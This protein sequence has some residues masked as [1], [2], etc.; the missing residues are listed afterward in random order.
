[1]QKLRPREVYVLI[2]PN[3]VHMTLVA[4]SPTVRFL[5]I[6]CIVKMHSKTHCTHLILN[7]HSHHI[8]SQR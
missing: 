8:S 4:S 2:Y 5:E 7:E 6:F 1:M 3:G